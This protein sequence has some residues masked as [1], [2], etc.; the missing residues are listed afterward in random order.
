M[1]Y[2]VERL[3]NGFTL[4]RCRHSGLQGMYDTRSGAYAFGELLIENREAILAIIRE[5][6]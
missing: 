6:K 3:P 1:R 2:F 4:I 5:C